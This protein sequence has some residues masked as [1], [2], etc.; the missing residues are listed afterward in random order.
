MPRDVR[1][2]VRM[3]MMGESVHAVKRGGTD[4]S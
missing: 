1:I 3:S 4:G 2:G